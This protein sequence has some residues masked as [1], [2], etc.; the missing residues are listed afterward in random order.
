[1]TIARVRRLTYVFSL[2]LIVFVFTLLFAAPH[3]YGG[4]QCSKKA[5]K[6]QINQAKPGFL[7]TKY[8]DFIFEVLCRDFSGDGLIDM[9]FVKGVSGTAGTIGW[10]VFNGTGEGK[11]QLTLFRRNEYKVQVAP[12]GSDIEA[13]TPIYKKNDPNC[14]PSAFRVKLWRWNG[15][16]Y[17]VAS[18]HDEPA[19]K[20]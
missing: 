20:S 7:A 16:K 2:A 13:T 17:A 8:G 18:S 4:G 14:C 1:M 3:S 9:A 5:A 11:W 6:Q 10:G 19:P 12:K 15:D